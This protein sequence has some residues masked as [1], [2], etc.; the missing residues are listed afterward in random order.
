MMATDTTTTRPSPTTRP[1]ET[2][3]QPVGRPDEECGC[4]MPGTGTGSGSAQNKPGTAKTYRDVNP[5]KPGR[6][7]EAIDSDRGESGIE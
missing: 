1:T 3:R 4:D 2:G 6:S 5:D 7:D